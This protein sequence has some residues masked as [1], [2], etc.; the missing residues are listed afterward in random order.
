MLDIDNY[1]RV[2]EKNAYIRDCLKTERLIK[3][4]VG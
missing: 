4:G 1:K 2:N 3:V